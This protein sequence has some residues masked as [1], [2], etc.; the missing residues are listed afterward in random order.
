GDIGHKFHVLNWINSIL[1][2]RGFQE[3]VR[4]AAWADGPDFPPLQLLPVEFLHLFPADQHRPVGLGEDAEHR[5]LGQ[6]VA[7]LPIDLAFGCLPERGGGRWTERP[8]P[9]CRRPGPWSARHRGPPRGRSPSSSPRR[10]ARSRSL[11]RP[12]C[13]ES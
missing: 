4:R 9:F 12:R 5:Y 11:A 2:Q 7:V 8:P 3:Q 10:W 1:P 13:S 6:R